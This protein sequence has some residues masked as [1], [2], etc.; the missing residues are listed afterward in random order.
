MQRG[1]TPLRRAASLNSVRVFNDL[2]AAV[3]G[4]RTVRR[5]RGR[6]DPALRPYQAGSVGQGRPGILLRR[7]RRRLAL[8]R[9]N[10][11]RH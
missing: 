5:V 11:I 6:T 8:A 3:E 4:D 2:R 9:A 7:S 1:P 10:V